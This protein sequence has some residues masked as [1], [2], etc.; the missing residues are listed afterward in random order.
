MK[1]TLKILT[2]GF[3]LLIFAAF[4]AYALVYVKVETRRRAH[5]ATP[6]REF[7]LPTD[8]ASLAEGQRLVKVKACADCHGAD[9]SGGIFIH[10]AGMGR[11]VAT[12]LTTGK[13]SAVKD[14]T[15]QDWLRAIRY[16]VART[17]RPLIGM[18]SGD[19]QATSDEDL[20]RIIAYLKSL[21]PVDHEWPKTRIGPLARI[22][23]V[24]H[25]LPLLFPYEEVNFDVVPPAK[26]TPEPTAKYGGYLANACSGCHHALFSGG[27][28]PG[29][30][31]SWPPAANLTPGGPLKNWTLEQF[32]TAMRTGKRPDG[33]E[34]NG[35]YMPWRSTAEMNN[36]ELE[37][38]Y[39]FFQS[40]PARD[41]GSD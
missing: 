1:S 28:V 24:S 21:P 18:P 7:S 41:L 15:P 11:W 35:N 30:P 4:M 31:S 13:G 34:I 36:V 16:G 12:N 32:M 37:A 14:Y 8:A 19:Y 27:P 22:L 25:K 39:H 6:T 38:L 20:G 26:V 2:S 5:I 17:G 10:D 9:F 29:V 33:S 40:L 23:Y 3:A